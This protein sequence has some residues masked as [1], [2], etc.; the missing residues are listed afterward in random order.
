MGVNIDK[1]R[2]AY[3]SDVESLTAGIII[4]LARHHKKIFDF[5]HDVNSGDFNSRDGVELFHNIPSKVT[6]ILKF[7]HYKSLF[8]LRPFLL[9]HF[10]IKSRVNVEVNDHKTKH[11][12]VAQS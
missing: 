4:L 9:R 5:T 7:S 8:R 3:V 11:K 6:F 2:P 1:M 12:R 10:D